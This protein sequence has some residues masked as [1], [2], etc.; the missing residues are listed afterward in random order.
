MFD[1][2]V[3][4]SVQV[5][6]AN[7]T[8]CFSSRGFQ[9]FVALITGWIAC[10]GRHHISRVIQAARG[11]GREKHHSALYRFLSRGSW[12]P[13][14]LGK[15]LF[16]LLLPLLPKEITSIVDDTLNHKSGP[17]IFG[18][19]MHYD[20]VQ[21]NYGRGTSAGRKAVFAFGHNWVV[22]AVWLPLPWGTRRGVAIPILFRLYRSK[23]RCPQ[24]KYRKR[25]ELATELVQLLASWL[26][27]ERR[28]HVV[29]DN[30]Y[31]CKTLVKALP[32]RTNYTGPLPMDAALYSQPGGYNG[33]GRPRCKGKRLP[34]PEA[35][36]GQRS[37]PWK[38]LTL[39]I[40]G[41]SV[42]VFVKSQRCLWY[43][44]AGIKLIRMVVTRDPAGR[45]DD[46]AYF[47]T[48]H[49]LAETAILVQFSRRWEIEVA[50]RNGKQAIGL[51]DPQNG[52]WRRKAGSPRPKKRPGPNPRGHRG[53]KAINH[54]MALAF[55]AY[56]L[57]IIWYLKNG[58]PTVDV[59]RAR[60]EA[61]WYRHKAAPSYADMLAAFR[62]E[63]WVATFSTHPL[64]SRVRVKVR[65]LLPR[66]LLAA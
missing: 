2:T 40:Y 12:T 5:L 35:L 29:A 61:P 28:L 49:K 46:R 66:W 30:E 21:S 15:V 55:A 8:S 9:N 31:S 36:A 7:F 64:F 32:R 18:T 45:I 43:T 23:K 53:E 33:K 27:E 42:T 10:Q 47:S 41:R 37:K 38:K 16:K 3:P 19:A 20:A 6:L 56:A 17:H 11:P 60:M 51:Q 65:E 62:R 26:P 22:L 63:L 14:S 24:A 52:W 25:T 50:F 1:A 59:E 57:V 48:E 39:T 4:P 54:T 13:D 44:V 34:S 58:K